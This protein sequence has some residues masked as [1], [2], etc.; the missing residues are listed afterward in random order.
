[1]FNFPSAPANPTP[2]FSRI[3]INYRMIGDIFSHHRTGADQGVTA[4]GDPADNGSIGPDASPL[5]DQRRKIIVRR[6][7]GI[8]AA[9]GLHVGKDHARPT[10]NIVFEN[11]PFVDAD[12]VLYLHV[13][14]DLSIFGDKDILPDLT[15]LT[16][17]SARHDMAEMPDLRPF[18]DLNRRIN[19]CRFVDKV[20]FIILRSFQP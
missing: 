20:F 19:V 10:E 15:A 9:G 16:D 5:L 4:D 17:N 7:A 14:T 2:D 12:I 13:V 8:S 11:D 1:M 18:P 3:A 6:I